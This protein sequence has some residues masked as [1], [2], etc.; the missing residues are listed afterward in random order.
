M[1]D[2]YFWPTS[3]GYKIL[4]FLLEI[5]LTHDIIPVDINADEQFAERFVCLFPN[6]KIPAILDRDPKDGGAPIAVFE[7]AAI[8]QYLAEKTGALLPSNIRPRLEALQW[9]TWQV[10][11]L[12][13]M[14]GQTHHFNRYAPVKIEYAIRR[15]GDET[16]RLYGV[17]ER[18]LSDR[19]YVADDFS[20]A[21][22]AIYPWIRNH[23]RQ[24]IDLADFPN[25]AR[26]FESIRARPAVQSAY[27]I[28]P[29]IKRRHRGLDG[30]AEPA[31][32]TA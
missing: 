7:S 25:T 19:A 22:I 4:I 21:D 10:A 17:L 20:I 6:S 28:G 24:G 9:L 27:T 5:G 12:G 23:P 32:A 2:F 16:R 13:P 14:A 29:S 26:W 1:I 18:R 3:N 15:Y 30:A 11:G 31:G 8:L